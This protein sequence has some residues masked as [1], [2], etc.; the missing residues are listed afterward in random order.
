MKRVKM[1]RAKMRHDD[2]VI[3]MPAAYIWDGPHATFVVVIGLLEASS[4]LARP[5]K[6]AIQAIGQRK[7]RSHNP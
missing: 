6:P 2:K 3:R 1:S 4:L 5:F 7:P